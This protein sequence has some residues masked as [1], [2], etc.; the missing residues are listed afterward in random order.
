LSVRKFVHFLQYMQHQKTVRRDLS[1][2]GKQH[3]QSS[4]C[5]A[6][7]NA[8]QRKQMRAEKTLHQ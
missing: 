7:S 8:S 4:A 3:L 1:S 6:V 2:V 5:N